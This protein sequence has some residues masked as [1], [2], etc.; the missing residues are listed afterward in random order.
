MTSHGFHEA[1]KIVYKFSGDQPWFENKFP[2]SK[3]KKIETHF[4]NAIDDIYWLVV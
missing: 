2:K 1:S 3:P 4:Q